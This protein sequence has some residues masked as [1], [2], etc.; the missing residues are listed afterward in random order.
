MPKS[1]FKINESILRKST[2]LEIMLLRIVEVVKFLSSRGLHFHGE[3]AIL[4]STN[5]GNFLRCIE[6]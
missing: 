4:G 5:N 3:N 1:W 2:I 6:L